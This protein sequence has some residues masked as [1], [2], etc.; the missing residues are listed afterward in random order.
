MLDLHKFLIMFN[1]SFPFV[2][3]RPFQELKTILVMFH[4]FRKLSAWLTDRLCK[5]VF[6]IIGCHKAPAVR[7]FSKYHENLNHTTR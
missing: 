2:Y 5:I 4:D 6:L 3:V 1:L 7:S